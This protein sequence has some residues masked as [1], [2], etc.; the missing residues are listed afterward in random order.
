MVNIIGLHNT[1]LDKRLMSGSKRSP[2]SGRRYNKYGPG[3]KSSKT[4]IITFL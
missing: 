3:S 1:N 4:M 2:F